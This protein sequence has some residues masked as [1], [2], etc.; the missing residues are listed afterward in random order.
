MHSALFAIIAAF[1]TFFSFPHAQ[2]QQTVLHK[3]QAGFDG[4]EPRSGGVFDKAG[5]FYGTTFSGGNSSGGAGTV[6]EMSPPAM[7]GGAWTETVIHRFSYHTIASGLSPWG[8]LAI[9]Q[10]GN[11]FGTAW[12]GGTCGSCGLVF[13]LSPPTRQGGR[14]RYQIIHDFQDDGRDGINPRADLTVDAQGTHLFGTTASGG[15]G[16]CEG[17]CGTVF[18][19]TKSGGVWAE[20]ILH[21]CPAQGSGYEASGGTDGGVAID[22]AGDV[23]GTSLED[24]DFHL[25][26]VFE[27]SPPTQGGRWTYQDIYSFKS[28][29]D[30]FE[31]TAGV[32]FDSHGDLFG[33]TNSGGIQGCYGTGC[34]TVFRLHQ[35]ANGVWGHTILYAFKGLG[36]GGTPDA[37]VIVG[38]NGMVFGT[39]QIWGT[40]NGCTGSGCGVAFALTNPGG[41]GMWNETVLHTFLHGANGYVPYGELIF[42]PDGN[43]YGATQFGGRPACSSG[44]GCGTVYSLTP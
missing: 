33:T 9:D 18:E 34:G 1:T 32:S 5:D 23:Y 25:G 27:L 7:P 6:F 10:N 12:L 15:T 38:A 29:S 17:G 41:S 11:L 20:T 40:G 22:Q 43:L 26:S 21:S 19:L 31:P 4:Y 39:T 13:E 3:F 35:R 44:F 16:G 2:S 28:E 37:G 8:G 14:W 42:G 30:G 24:G 36:D